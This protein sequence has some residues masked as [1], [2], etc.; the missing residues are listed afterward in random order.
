MRAGWLFL[1]AALTAH[2][3]EPGLWTTRQSIAVLQVNTI[4]TGQVLMLGDS[5]TEAFWW[6]QLG[7]RYVINLGQ[8]SGG[9]EQAITA[10]HYVVPIAKP[11]IVTILIGINDCHTGQEADPSVWG[12]QLKALIE[13]LKANGAIP[14][15]ASILP[16]EAGKPLGAGYFNPACITALNAQLWYVAAPAE[17]KVNLNYHFMDSTGRMHPGWTVDGVHPTG[18][19]MRVLYDDLQTGLRQVPP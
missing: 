8:G 6:N 3:A 9:I 13:Y 7:G 19:A 1:L 12:Q 18:A 5:I 14:I 10:A 17:I 15:V 4:G 11:S 2:A 16:V